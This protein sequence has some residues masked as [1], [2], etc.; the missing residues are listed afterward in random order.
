MSK[1][2]NAL[3]VLGILMK[4]GYISEKCPPLRRRKYSVHEPPVGNKPCLTLGHITEGTF[5][6]MARNG[7]VVC[8]ESRQSRGSPIIYNSYK[9]ALPKC[10]VEEAAPE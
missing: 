7:L 8:T 10:H 5:E 9:M 6:S 4:G 2:M 1:A 3:D